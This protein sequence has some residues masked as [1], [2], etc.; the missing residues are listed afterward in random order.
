MT[1]WNRNEVEV[2]G[3]LGEGTENLE[4]VTSG[5]L[6]RIKVVLPRKSY[7]SDDTDLVVRVPRAAACP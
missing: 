2:T 6:T 4:F 7:S 3:E 5:K 1:G